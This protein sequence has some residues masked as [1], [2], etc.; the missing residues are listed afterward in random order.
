MVSDTSGHFLYVGMCNIDNRFAV[1]ATRFWRDREVRD[2]IFMI[3]VAA[4]MKFCVFAVNM[5]V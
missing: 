1:H 3:T 5:V 4:G 2:C